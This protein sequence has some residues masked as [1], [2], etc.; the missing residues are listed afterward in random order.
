MADVKRPILLQLGTT[1]EAD[2][3]KTPRPRIEA[4]Q[5]QPT[6][7]LASVDRSSICSSQSSASSSSTNSATSPEVSSPSLIL[8]Y[9]YVGDQAQT[10]IDTISSL[11]ISY[12]LSLQSLPKFLSSSPQSTSPST[13]TTDFSSPSQQEEIVDVRP[14]KSQTCPSLYVAP[15]AKTKNKILQSENS[16]AEAK[17]IDIIDGADGGL[18]PS[19]NSSKD[20]VVKI[21]K[22]LTNPD[23]SQQGGDIAETAN[24][25]LLDESEDQV[26]PMD[27]NFDSRDGDILV[28]N[29]PSPSTLDSRHEFN[30]Q[31]RCDNFSDNSDERLAAILE[32]SRMQIV[33]D[34]SEIVIEPR[35]S[36]EAHQDS[37]L[38][39][40]TAVANS[41]CSLKQ[42]C[43]R[44]SSSVHRL[45]K[46][47]C[48][49]ISDTFEQLLD[50][51]FDETHSFIEEARRNKCNV[52][53]HC[54]AGIS[55]SPT[56]AIAYLMKWK[57][58]HLQE[59]YNFVKRCRP[60]ISPNLNFM[61]QLVSY[62]R[63][64]QRSHLPSPTS[65]CLPSL[66]ISCSQQQQQQ[67]QQQSSHSDSSS[68][69]VSSPRQQLV[70][71][72]NGSGSRSETKRVHSVIRRSNHNSI[73]TRSY[74][75]NNK[76]ARVRCFFRR[77]SHIE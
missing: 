2:L 68:S 5:S 75:S 59:A 19:A 23:G 9:L 57:R 60:Q 70:G 43:N 40:A 24:A 51:F 62:E 67:Q 13:P 55:R 15:R 25:D 4:S 49:N 30:G 22:H 10:Q 11:N 28:K 8:P 56:I 42:R 27:V 58:L 29:L 6:K 46:G 76:R 45:I 7:S 31:D 54:K 63:R 71:T 16:S 20:Y 34:K 26:E 64:L 21:T 38:A 61:G 50:K 72:K 12:I 47:K 77:K 52:L 33:S 73:D 44:F 18:L 36:D 48:I 32:D 53:V 3:R 39:D 41:G 65:S 37:C 74:D 17:S 66:R 69:L 14:I 35:T 1:Q